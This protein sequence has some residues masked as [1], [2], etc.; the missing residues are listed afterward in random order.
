MCPFAVGAFITGLK[1]GAFLMEMVYATTPEACAYTWTVGAGMFWVPLLAIVALADR[2]I[3]VSSP[4]LVEV[5]VALVLGISQKHTI[6]Q[7]SFQRLLVF[8]PDLHFPQF[9]ASFFVRKAQKI[10]QFQ[11]VSAFYLLF[12]NVIGKLWIHTHDYCFVFN[13][14]CL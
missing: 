13:Y 10:G 14:L 12:E 2:L 11:I 3:S 8:K 6:L 4:T 1:K 9:G 7:Y 5:W